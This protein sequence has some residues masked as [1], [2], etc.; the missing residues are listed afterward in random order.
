MNIL[1]L[2][3][4]SHD[5]AAS[6]VQGSTVVS[7]A[8]EERFSRVENTSEFPINAINYCVQ[9]AGLSLLDL[10]HVAFSAQPYLEFYRVVLAH[11]RAWPFSLPTFLRTIPHWLQDRLVLPMVLKSELGFE[12]QVLFIKHHLSHAA[13]AF[14]PSPFEEAAIVTSDGVG[15]WAAM[16]YGV[17]RGHQIEILKEIKYP[18]SLGLLY[19]AVTSYLG[20]RAHRDEDTVMGLAAQGEP[21]YQEQFAQLVH[22]AHDGSFHMDPRFWDINWGDRLYGRR[23]VELFGPPRSPGDELEQRHADMAATVQRVVEEALLAVTRHVHQV[24]GMDSLCLAG[25]TFLNSVANQRILEESPFRRLFIQP[26]AGDAGGS[27]GAALYAGASLLDRRRDYCMTSAYLGPGFSGE[28]ARTAVIN[29]GLPHVELEEDE[30]V[31]EVAR[32]VAGGELVGWVQGRVAFGP[33][34]LGNRTI[35][36]DPRDA[37]LREQ[38]G[39][40]VRPLEGASPLAL[41]VQEEKAEEFFCPGQPSPFMLLAPRIREDRRDV[42][43][44]AAHPDGTAR[45]QTVNSQSNRLLYLLLRAFGALTGVPVLINTSFKRSGEPMVCTPRDAIDCFQETDLDHLVIGMYLVTRPDTAGSLGSDQDEDPPGAG[46]D[47]RL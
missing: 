46:V 35:L 7:A 47:A 22:V 10:D 37:R 29:S 38:I 19:A 16:T 18:S 4:H 33:R 31:E 43:P 13:S 12:G 2:A 14:L 8:Q 27:L 17:G 40:K 5:S 26:A 39:S 32:L 36:G 3:I 9:A 6:L 28:E 11:L 20:Y 24:T 30:L 42:I 34:A 23:F 15:E 45:V 25:G 41:M 1:G 21:V 44:A